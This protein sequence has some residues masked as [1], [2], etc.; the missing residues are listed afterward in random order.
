MK[1][2]QGKVPKLSCPAT[3]ERT[4]F[5]KLARFQDSEANAIIT[6]DVEKD[7]K[8]SEFWHQ[9]LWNWSMS[10][11]FLDN[12]SS[13]Q[14]IK[15]GNIFNYFTCLGRKY[16]SSAFCASYDQKAWLFLMTG[17]QSCENQ[18]SCVH[19]GEGAR[20]PASDRSAFSPCSASGQMTLISSRCLFELPFSHS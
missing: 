8:G 16:S 6:P 10:V 13:H 15:C 12:W 19:T 20:R 3:I 18:L 2:Y 14:N 9:R 4:V 1:W 17:E 5:I 11:N 7:R